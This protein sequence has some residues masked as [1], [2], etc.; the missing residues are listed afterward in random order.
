MVTVALDMEPENTEE[1][2]TMLSN[3]TGGSG[4]FLSESKKLEKVR[5]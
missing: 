4:T 3:L 1:V 2:R 5:I